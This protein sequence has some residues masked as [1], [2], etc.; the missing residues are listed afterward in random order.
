MYADLIVSAYASAKKP[1]IFSL[2]LSIYNSEGKSHMETKHLQN[3]YKQIINIKSPDRT[4]VE[5][6]QDHDGRFILSKIFGK[7]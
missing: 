6:Q 2:C 7:E 4:Y 3:H 5:I 1:L